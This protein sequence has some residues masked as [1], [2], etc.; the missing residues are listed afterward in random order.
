MTLR[1]GLIGCGFIGRFHA[2]NLKHLARTQAPLAYVAVCDRDLER[3]E[4][5]ARIGGCDI[6]TNDAYQL[7]E[8]RDVDALY[9]CTETSEH[10]ALVVAAAAAGKHV[11]CEKPLAKTYAEAKAMFDA[12][13]A[14]GVTHQVGLVLRFSPV[15]RVLEDLMADPSLGRPLAVQMR[16]DQFFP[17][18]GHYASAW[19][20]DVAKAGG[21]TLIEHSIHDV[22]L[23]TRLFGPVN[24]VRCQTRFTSG[25]PGIEDVASVS[26]EHP[27]GLT[28]QLLSVWHAMD[29]RPSTRRI[30]VFFERGWLMTE[31]DYFGSVTVQR[32]RGDPVEIPR[33]QVLQ[34]FLALERLD[35]DGYD[36]RSVGALGDQRFMEAARAGRPALPSFREAVAAHR[37]VDACYRSARLQHDVTVADVG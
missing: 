8:S 25:H 37:V 6:A 23:L 7:I 20:G 4:A 27:D 21:G 14:A 15:Y 33:E 2:S 3:A 22:D 9:V 13:E 19:R 31:H 1:I 24:R 5:Y 35:A 29:D 28:S 18:R 36:E 12:V 10:P 11:F 16:D 34:R 26:F 30:E 17:T 32:G